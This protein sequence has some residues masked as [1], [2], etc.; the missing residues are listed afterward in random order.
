VVFPA[1]MWALMPIFRYRSMGVV[2]ATFFRCLPLFA[3][4]YTYASR[5]SWSA[6]PS[7]LVDLS[8]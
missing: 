4:V 8:S 6:R 3:A 5:K 7:P 2:L 1:S